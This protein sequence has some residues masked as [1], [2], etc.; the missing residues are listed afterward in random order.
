MMPDAQLK[1][2][3]FKTLLLARAFEE[4]RLMAC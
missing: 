1:V 2:G 3:L 4:K